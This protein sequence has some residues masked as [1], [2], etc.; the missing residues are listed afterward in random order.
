MAS[1]SAANFEKRWKMGRALSGSS[2]VSPH[3]FTWPATIHDHRSKRSYG[4]P[5][6]RR[7]FAP[8]IRTGSGQGLRGSAPYSLFGITLLLFFFIDI[9]SHPTS[10]AG[11]PS[12]GR[13]FYCRA[14]GSSRRLMRVTV[15]GLAREKFRVLWAMAAMGSLSR[16]RV[17][18][19]RDQRRHVPPPPGPCVTPRITPLSEYLPPR[20]AHYR[21]VD[22]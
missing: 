18:W 1:N 20:T 21:W 12:Q 17:L 22:D 13:S 19:R 3:K 9:R 14:R 5:H 16:A 11:Q 8:H 4:S 7:L 6:P 2:N 10:F 15:S